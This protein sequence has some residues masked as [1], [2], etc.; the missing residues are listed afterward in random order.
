M[1]SCPVPGALEYPT[2]MLW[3]LPQEAYLL[4]G[5]K[6]SEQTTRNAVWQCPNEYTPHQKVKTP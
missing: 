2:K 3:L 1:S 5:P 6:D 4:Q